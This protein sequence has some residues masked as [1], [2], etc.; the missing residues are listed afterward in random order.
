MGT[1]GGYKMYASNKKPFTLYKR[2]TKKRKNIYYVRFNM[3]DGSRSSGKSTGQT[4]ERKAEI[5]AYNVLQTGK[6][7]SKPNSTFGGFAKGFFDYNSE[8]ATD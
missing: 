1:T 8:W 2:K 4:S 6:I 7:V 5:W 3:P